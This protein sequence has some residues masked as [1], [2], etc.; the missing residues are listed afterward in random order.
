M[1]GIILFSRTKSAVQFLAKHVKQSGDRKGRFLDVLAVICTLKKL[2]PETCND[3]RDEHCAV[4]IVRLC[5]KV[6]GTGNLHRIELQSS[7]WYT[8]LVQVS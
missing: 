4:V 6:S 8:F 7:F 2:V 3:A 1:V 5:L